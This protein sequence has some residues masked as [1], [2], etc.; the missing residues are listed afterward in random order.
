MLKTF[1][2][3]S[4]ANS[5]FF[6]EDKI[7]TG[8]VINNFLSYESFPKTSAAFINEL[9]LGYK[10]SGNE[11]WHQYYNYPEVAISFFAGSLGNKKEFGNIK[12][13]LPIIDFC[14][15]NSSKYDI[16]LSLGWGIAYFNKPYDSITNPHNILIG[17]HFTHFAAMSLSYQ[18]HLKNNFRLNLTGAYLHASNGHYQVPNG[19]MNLATIAV[20]AKK[21]FGENKVL[22]R[23]DKKT[24]REKKDFYLK[25][26]CGIHEF[27]GT[28]YPTGTPKYKVYTATFL[29]GK[30][31]KPFIKYFIGF[32]GKF[33]EAFK[34]TI[35]EENLY[36]KNFFLKSSIFTF[37]LGNEFQFGNFAIFTNGGLN[38]YTPFVKQHVYKK[39]HIYN[40][41]NILELY[42][43]SKLGM[44]YYLFD[45]Q[46]SKHNLFVSWAIKA[47]FGNADFTEVSVGVVL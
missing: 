6:A 13:I 40:I 18:I 16:D 17:S 8:F 10:T 34:T 24:I 36:S 37:V 39:E 47:N 3:S 5:Q 35:E 32:T 19:G 11:E 25:F 30:N 31:Y 43:S 20:G 41:D 46:T 21:Y 4:Q 7:Y 33:Y 38:I 22:S 28:L 14:L 45:P 12:G 26:G 1:E 42:I 2:S 44:R 23:T 15:K 9:K 29:Y 27:A